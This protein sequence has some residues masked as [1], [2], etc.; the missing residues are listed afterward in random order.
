MSAEVVQGLICVP[1]WIEQPVP[2]LVCWLNLPL[3]FSFF[4]L[5]VKKINILADTDNLLTY[6]KCILINSKINVTLQ[7]HP[8]DN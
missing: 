7:L 2:R 3:P 5:L 6:T 8:G 1:V 4:T